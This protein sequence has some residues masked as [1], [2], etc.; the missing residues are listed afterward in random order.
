M[1]MDEGG[2]EDETKEKAAEEEGAAEKAKQ[3]VDEA[4]EVK[5]RWDRTTLHSL[6]A[7]PHLAVRYMLEQ[8]LPLML[9]Q[10]RSSTRASRLVR[11]EYQTLHGKM[12]GS[13][14]F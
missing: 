5:V 7:I 8:H 13:L 2:G 14:D 4:Q 11:P 6:V 9:Q 12:Q 3:E 1:E 10:G